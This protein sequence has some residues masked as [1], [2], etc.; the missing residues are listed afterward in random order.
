MGSSVEISA[1]NQ[2]FEM[3]NKTFTCTYYTDPGHGWFKVKRSV[4]HNLNI[5]HLVSSYSYQRGEYVYLEEDCDITLL[6]HAL[7]E[8]GTTLLSQHKHTDND[9]RIRTY[10][11]YSM[12]VPNNERCQDAGIDSSDAVQ[13]TADDTV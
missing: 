6:Y 12:A 7:K 8:Q 11:R 3:K 10:E 5:A 4:L 9:S 1:T 2:R 13:A